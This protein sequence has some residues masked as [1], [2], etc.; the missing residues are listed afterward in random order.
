[1]TVIA[2]NSDPITKACSVPTTATQTHALE[3]GPAIEAVISSVKSLE[4]VVVLPIL[5][6][7]SPD[8]HCKVDASYLFE[9][10]SSLREEFAYTEPKT[11]VAKSD[12]MTQACIVPSATPNRAPNRIAGC[13]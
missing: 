13:P 8:G 11:D 5:K 12:P 9:W 1:M 6:L 10:H 3:L 7:E 2:K 4:N